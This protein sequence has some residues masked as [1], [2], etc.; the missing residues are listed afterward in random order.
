MSFLLWVAVGVVVGLGFGFFIVPAAQ[1]QA[2]WGLWATIIGPFW[3]TPL[4]MYSLF[5]RGHP[6]S[7]R[8][9]IGFWMGFWA[10][11]TAVLAF[12]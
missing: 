12:A 4:V 7:M 9:W 10:T 2:D 6:A 5:K 11:S 3:A 8:I 1:L